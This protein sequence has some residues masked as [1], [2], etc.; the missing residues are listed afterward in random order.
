MHLRFPFLLQMTV[1]STNDDYFSSFLGEGVDRDS[2]SSQ[3][4]G[5]SF[6]FILVL[7][8]IPNLGL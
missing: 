6:S 3:S 8:Q 1:L 4:H 5:P 2:E 7:S